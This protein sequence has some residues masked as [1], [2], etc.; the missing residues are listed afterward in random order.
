MPKKILLTFNPVL[1]VK[2]ETFRG[3]Y[4]IH[5]MMDSQLKLQKL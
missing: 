2:I 1:K 3:I 5:T 4:K